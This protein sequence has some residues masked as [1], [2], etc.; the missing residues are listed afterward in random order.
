MA[1]LS[2]RARHLLGMLKKGDEAIMMT[3][4]RADLVDWSIDE[5]DQSVEELR[6]AKL[7]YLHPGNGEPTLH[8]GTEEDD[9]PYIPTKEMQR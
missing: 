6:Q 7:A 3:E 5:I 9:L 2:Q 4:I 1:N 8:L